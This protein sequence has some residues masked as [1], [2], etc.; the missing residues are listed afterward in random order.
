VAE[1]HDALETDDAL[2][3]SRELNMN[4]S[5]SYLLRFTHSSM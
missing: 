3:L 5:R 1:K 2:E 4:L